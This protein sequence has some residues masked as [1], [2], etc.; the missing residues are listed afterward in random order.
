[1]G[2]M[3]FT[4]SGCGTGFQ[5]WDFA[6]NKRPRCRECQKEKKLPRKN[7]RRA[8]PTERKRR[9][10]YRRQTQKFFLSEGWRQLRYMAFK[11]HGRKCLVCSSTENV[12]HV[13]HIKPRSKY[14]ELEYDIKNLQVLCEDCNL[15]KGVGDETDWRVIKP[16]TPEW[17]KLAVDDVPG[18]NW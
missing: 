3:M 17:E 13:D 2:Y 8:S 10:T 18:T 6:T 14:P 15:G 4:C 12:L 5:A 16:G 11:I 7:T 1:M 9:R